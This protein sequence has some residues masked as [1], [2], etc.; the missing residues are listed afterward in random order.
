VS[1][2][3]RCNGREDVSRVT[4]VGFGGLFIE[5]A[6]PQPVGSAAKI[7]FLVQ[8]GQITADAVVRYVKPFSGLGL[9]FTAMPE[10]DRPRLGTLLTRLRHCLDSQP[11]IGKLAHAKPN[12]SV[13]IVP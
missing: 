8:E 4:D 13:R 9:Q 1:V 5:T 2:Y 6:T 3:W 11:Q 7:G 12:A 10:K